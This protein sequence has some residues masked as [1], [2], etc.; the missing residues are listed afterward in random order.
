MLV[1]MLG[2]YGTDWINV[3][4]DTEKWWAL[5]NSVTNVPVL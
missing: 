3:A 1:W 2:F 4:Q 5:V